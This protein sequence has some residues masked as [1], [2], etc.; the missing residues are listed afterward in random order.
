MKTKEP[1]LTKFIKI[2]TFENYNVKEMFGNLDDK[3]FEFARK[4]KNTAKG[5]AE[6]SVKLPNNTP[7]PN[8][9]PVSDSEAR[10][11]SMKSIQKGVKS[12]DLQSLVSNVK[13]YGK[14]GEKVV[15]DVSEA[16]KTIK[17]NLVNEMNN[18]SILERPKDLYNLG[19]TQ[20]F[21]PKTRKRY[22]Y[23]YGPPEYEYVDS[24]Y[25]V[26]KK[27]RRLIPS[28]GDDIYDNNGKLDVDKLDK[29]IERKGINYYGIKEMIESGNYDDLPNKNEVINYLKTKKKS[30]QT[31]LE[32]DDLYR[33]I[34]ETE[35][36]DKKQ[37]LNK[38]RQ[39]N[40]NKN[41]SDAVS[42]PSDNNIQTNITIHKYTHHDAAIKK[43]WI[44]LLEKY[45]N[46]FILGTGVKI[47]FDYYPSNCVL[48]NRVL[49]ELDEDK[50]I[51]ISRNNFLH[52]LKH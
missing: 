40:I 11:T 31:E 37:K 44:K 38:Q 10:N 24:N 34:Q 50:A 35:D 22:Y 12:N 2:E 19:F 42:S 6:H 30:K 52:M 47:D 49:S 39:T 1:Q 43:E 41:L 26:Y 8:N 16:A 5:Y 13:D 33:E 23:M 46:N 7:P 28:S 45:S 48:V 3:G 27:K 4:G 36:E 9:T 29:Q 51:K 25:V 15:D 32:S 21:D 14:D 20:Y 17:D 18:K